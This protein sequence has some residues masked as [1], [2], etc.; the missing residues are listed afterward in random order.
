MRRTLA[1]LA[2]LAAAALCAATQPAV[3]LTFEPGDL[4]VTG[5]SYPIGPAGACNNQFCVVDPTSGAA[6]P[7]AALPS[8]ATYGTPRRLVVTSST[9]V[10]ALTDKALLRVNSETGVVT[11]IATGLSTGLPG[12]GL[13]TTPSGRVF[14]EQLNPGTGFS[15]HEVNV[16]TG[17]L[18][19]VASG[20][21]LAT[22][23]FGESLT[24]LGEVQSADGG[25]TGYLP[26]IRHD[27]ASATGAEI[28]QLVLDP[29]YL[30]PPPA[31]PSFL[32]GQTIRAFA[33]GPE[34]DVFAFQAYG[35]SI[36]EGKL[37]RLGG[38]L[39]TL[40]LVPGETIILPP[41]P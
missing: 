28:G 12:G 3:A 40:V 33:V 24:F 4:V 36:T 38:P 26:L 16:T 11:P 2:A 9:E 5:F 32:D 22:G 8:F 29:Y 25:Y 21:R 34:G 39:G 17:A 10:L 7:F 6:T 27:L 20:V 41:L 15:V 31:P 18:T 23:T 30:D 13:A 14:I 19:L 1:A 37:T 35:A